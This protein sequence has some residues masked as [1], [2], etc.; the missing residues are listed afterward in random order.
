MSQ[1]FMRETL[2]G[3]EKIVNPYKSD[4]QSTKF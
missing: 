4:K 2:S 3:G 1:L